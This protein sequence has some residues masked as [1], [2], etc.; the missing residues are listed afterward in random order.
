M[1][2]ADRLNR[3]TTPPDI[4]LPIAKQ[5]KSSMQRQTSDSFIDCAVKAF[6]KKKMK[7]F[8]FLI[9]LYL[10]SQWDKNGDAINYSKEFVVFEKKGIL[11]TSSWIKF[12]KSLFSD[13][14]G[15]TKHTKTIT[16][17]HDGTGETQFQT[18]KCATE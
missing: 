15:R 2:V 7:L 4:D 12:C 10:F 18:I 16:L 13:Q 8:F 11:H 3:L 14:I 5:K 17:K 6:F 9:V 1:A